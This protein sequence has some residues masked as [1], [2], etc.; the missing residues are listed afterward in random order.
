M[1]FLRYP[2]HALIKPIDC[3]QK[4][5]AKIKIVPI[6]TNTQSPSVH[7]YQILK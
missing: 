2:R 3:N 7:G 1:W 6:A 4:A 5:Y